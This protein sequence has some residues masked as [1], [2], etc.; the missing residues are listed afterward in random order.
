MF[1]QTFQMQKIDFC[2]NQCSVMF[3]QRYSVH[4]RVSG[5]E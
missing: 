1:I 4:F 2:S 5:V 3:D